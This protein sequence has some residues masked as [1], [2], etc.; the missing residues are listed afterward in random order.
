MRCK[1]YF[2]NETQGSKEIPEIPG[3]PPQKGSPA[4]ELFL[5]KTEQNLFS[6]FPGK[7]GAIELD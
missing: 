3:S 4:L 1:C 2:R 5:N 7:A 6:V